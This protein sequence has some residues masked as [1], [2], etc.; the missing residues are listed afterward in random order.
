MSARVYEVFGRPVSG[1]PA[2]HLGSLV[3]DDDELAGLYANQIFGRRGENQ[4]IAVVARAD[5]RPGKVYAR[6]ANALRDVPT[7]RGQSRGERDG[8]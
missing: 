2:A 4:D 6:C 5:V 3:A 7:T 1:K 8:A